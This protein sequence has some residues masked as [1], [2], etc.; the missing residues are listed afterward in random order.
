MSKTNDKLI[1]VAS[2]Y[3]YHPETPNCKG[4]PRIKEMVEKRR[5]E[6]VLE[7]TARLFKDDVNLFSP[8]VYSHHIVQ[9][10]SMLGGE[11]E[12]WQ[13]F[14]ELM[15]RKSDALIVLCLDGWKESVGVS[16]ELERADNI[17]LPLHFYDID[18]IDRGLLLSAFIDE[19]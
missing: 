2:P 7:F 3:T 12:A 9:I 19:L 11:W 15:I 10:S 8:V 13:A 6:Q 5:Y 16:A 14:D 4:G 18:L 17:G 1:Y